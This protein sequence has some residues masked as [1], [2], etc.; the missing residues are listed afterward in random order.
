[1]NVLKGLALGLLIFLLVLSLP[2]FGVAFLVNQTILNPG[3]VSSQINKL[4]VSLLAEEL[5]SEQIPEEA[6]PEEFGDVLVNTITDL[7]PWI[8]QQ[9]SDGIYSSYEYL[10]GRSQTLSV[11]IPLEPV[12]E[13]LR[14]NMWQAFLESLPPELAGASPAEL[15]Q[16]FDDFY[17]EFSEQIP[18]TYE[19]TES[20]LP[21]EVLATVEQVKQAI[22]Y[23]QTGYKFLIGLIVLLIAGIA[24]IDR[25][26]RG[27]SRKLGII[28]LPEGVLMLVGV[29]VVKN[30]AGTQ[31][32]QLDIPPYLQEW[33]P[34]LVSDFVS[35]L[36]ML[37]I[38][39]L[40]GGVALLTFSFIYKRQD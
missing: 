16:Y 10:M 34:Q 6:F 28:L 24:I 39:L 35:P 13:S 31:I 37:S 22:S 25:Q 1:M 12:K 19:I 23:F 20:S 36:L 11:V 2:I 4:D 32:A 8:Q 18:S 15:A 21:P 5:I 38:G 3:F 17:Q 30:L 33:L 9:A 7:E 40:V 29:F 27:T 26:I 14:D